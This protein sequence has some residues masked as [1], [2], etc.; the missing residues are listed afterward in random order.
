M[1]ILTCL[2]DSI[3][4]CYHCFSDDFLGNGYVKM[5]SERFCSEGIDCYVR[6]QGIDGFTVG[7]LLQKTQRDADLSGN[8]ITILIGINDIG[9]MLNTHRT[10]KQQNMMQQSFQSQYAELLTILTK[11]TSKIILMEPFLFPWPAFYHTWLPFRQDMANHIQT[12]AKEFRLPYLTLHQEL[13]EEAHKY[14]YSSIT[15]D[16]IHL[17]C[18][19]QKFLA[20]RLYPLLLSFGIS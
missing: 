7:R 6:N 9:M 1:T 18:Q 3:T 12:L 16:G 2:G 20:D 8:I 10:E 4:D 17:T 11:H 15:T 19:G 14:G 5:L 13:N